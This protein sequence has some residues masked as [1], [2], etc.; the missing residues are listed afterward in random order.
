MVLGSVPG[1]AGARSRELHRF[2]DPLR[3]PSPGVGLLLLE[4]RIHSG[5]IYPK[6]VHAGRAWTRVR[7]RIGQDWFPR[8][9][10]DSPR[11]ARGNPTTPCCTYTQPKTPLTPGDPA[12]RTR[13][14][15][16]APTAP[17]VVCRGPGRAPPMRKLAVVCLS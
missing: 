14:R 9:A 12:P 16:S 10:R 13:R 8:I 1:E 2:R 11:A 15:R 7:R 3:R 17:D 4:T 5:I 6:G